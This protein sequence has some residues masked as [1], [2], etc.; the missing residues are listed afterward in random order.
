MAPGPVVRIAVR[1]LLQSSPSYREL[2]PDKRREIASNTTRVASY[3]ADPHGLLSKKQRSRT[4]AQGR[5]PRAATV[6]SPRRGAPAR[7]P[8]A[9]YVAGL[10]DPRA[11]D[12]STAAAP[13]G[14]S[15][16]SRASRP[17]R[18]RPPAA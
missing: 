17:A 14:S 12:A 2:P 7:I 18:T 15:A 3:M 9:A 11:S 4:D 8:A 10:A 16:T 13:R 1:K 5:Q 6:L